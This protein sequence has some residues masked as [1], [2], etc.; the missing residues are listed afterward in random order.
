MTIETC[1]AGL[2]GRTSQSSRRGGEAANADQALKQLRLRIVVRVAG[3]EGERA[4][5]EEQREHRL[6]VRMLAVRARA[7]AK[8]HREYR[9]QPAAESARQDVEQP[10]PAP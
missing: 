10:V 6:H 2:S 3:D 8:P 4:C 7:S 1:S 5:R 9:A